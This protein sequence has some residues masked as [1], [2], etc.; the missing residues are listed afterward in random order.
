M[1]Q[2]ESIPIPLTRDDLEHV[3]ASLY[4][5]GEFIPS[6]LIKDRPSFK[7]KSERLINKLLNPLVYENLPDIKKPKFIRL[8]WRQ[9]DID[10]F[11]VGFI[12]CVL[13]LGMLKII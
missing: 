10:S 7:N 5:S 12:F 1:E 9:I 4:I 2:E 13:I 3:V 6:N 8:Q 11:I